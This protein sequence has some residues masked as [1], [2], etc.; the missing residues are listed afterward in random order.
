MW[1]R[2]ID[3]YWKPISNQWCRILWPYI[4]PY[5][6]ITIEDSAGE[7]CNFGDLCLKFGVFSKSISCLHSFM[8]LFVQHAKALASLLNT[9]KPWNKY[10]QL[11]DTFHSSTFSVYWTKCPVIMFQLWVLIFNIFQILHRSNSQICS[12]KTNLIC[13]QN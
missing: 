5:Q 9:P 8:S 4:N 6:G 1:Y 10:F 13:L 3:W 12:F 11:K 7:Y 2:L